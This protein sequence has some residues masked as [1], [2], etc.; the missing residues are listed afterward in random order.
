MLNLRKTMT[1]ANSLH[2]VIDM[3]NRTSPATYKR[4]D[5]TPHICIVRG[6]DIIIYGDNFRGEEKLRSG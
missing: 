6:E 1:V 4:D 3:T 2:S 5:Y